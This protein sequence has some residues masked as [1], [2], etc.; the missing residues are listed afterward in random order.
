M[1]WT[2]D[3]DLAFSGWGDLINPAYPWI[4]RTE[5]SLN[6]AHWGSNSIGW[7]GWTPI[8]LLRK[9]G[10]QIALSWLYAKP[11]SV[12]PFQWQYSGDVIPKTPIVRLVNYVATYPRRSNNL[13]TTSK[14]LWIT[15]A[16]ILKECGKIM[17]DFANNFG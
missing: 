12:S 7:A 15:R 3:L 14:K 10:S 4:N 5:S 2:W 13:R 9:P 17:A 16:R 8:G 1:W 6:T 11:S